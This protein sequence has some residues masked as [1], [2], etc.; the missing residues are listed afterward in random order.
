MVNAPDGLLREERKL[1]ASSIH[2][3]GT[4]HL[5]HVISRYFGQ[6]NRL[7]NEQKPIGD[8][9]QKMA[10]FMLYYHRLTVSPILAFVASQVYVRAWMSYSAGTA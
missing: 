5:T 8:T 4:S 1:M 3:D 9:Y 2:F 6:A 7:I 10:R